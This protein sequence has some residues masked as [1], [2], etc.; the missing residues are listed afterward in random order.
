MTRARKRRRPRRLRRARRPTASPGHALRSRADAGSC[1]RAWAPRCCRRCR[2]RCARRAHRSL[3][4]DPAHVEHR[5]RPVAHDRVVRRAQL[6]GHGRLQARR[7]HRAAPRMQDG[8]QRSR[9]MQRLLAVKQPALFRSRREGAR[10]AAGMP[11]ELAPRHAAL[12]VGANREI[13]AAAGSEQFRDRDETLLRRHH[14]TRITRP[15][16]RAAGPGA[17]RRTGYP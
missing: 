12:A 1:R 3:R 2:G 10:D 11:R 8:E 4:R 5:L 9:K 6:L 15:A 17:R 7:Q 13:T 14:E 16:A